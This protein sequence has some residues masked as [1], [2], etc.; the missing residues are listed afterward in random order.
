[1]SGL[2]VP[3]ED[4]RPRVDDTVYLA[5]G[6]A[7][8]GDVEIGAESSLWPGAVLRGDE[9]GVRVG[10]RS[11]IQDR[12]VVH[13]E[14]GTP[15]IIGSGVSIGHAAVLHGCILED[16][17]L[18]GVGATVLDGAVVGKEA[19]IAAGAV[20]L[21]D[22]RVG[23]RELWGGVPARRL[24]DLNDDDLAVMTRSADN[25]VKRARQFKE[26]DETSG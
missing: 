10:E 17:C 25:Y 21:P 16:G 11:N 20:V 7:V 24:R 3:Y 9:A 22:V 12:C 2:I 5:P 6:S 18:I 1:M 13:V 15:T 8:V 23:S 14:F 19:F 26:A 4:A